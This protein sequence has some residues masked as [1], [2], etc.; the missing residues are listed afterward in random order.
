MIIYENIALRLIEEM[1]MLQPAELAP[2]GPERG[3]RRGLRCGRILA[4]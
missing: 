2:K 1:A 3:F 4:D